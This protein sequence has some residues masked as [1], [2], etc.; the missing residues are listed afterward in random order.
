MDET[1]IELPV[2]LPWA[3]TACLAA[4]VACLGELWIIEKT[5]SQMLRDET[6]M[7]GAALKAAQNQVEAERIIARR[8]IE[9]LRSGGPQEAKGAVLLIP[10]GEDPGDPMAA[11]HPWGA[12]QWDAASQAGSFRFVD[13]PILGADRDYQL[14]IDAAGTDYPQGYLVGT[15]PAYTT[16]HPPSPLP[17]SHRF[18]LFNTPK[19]GFKTLDEAL[20]KGSI[21]LASHPLSPKI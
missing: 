16:V 12:S 21:I 3:T 10:P 6:L 18:L 2:W 1:K 8:E 15:G 9:G 7:A 4:L 19:G 5:R 20:T 11:G 13:L 17:A 14:W